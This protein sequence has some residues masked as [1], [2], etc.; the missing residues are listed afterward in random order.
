[1][2]E[3][4]RRIRQ[5]LE[6]MQP[7]AP[8]QAERWKRPIRQHDLAC[9][10]LADDASV[11]N[12]SKA[13]ARVL[14]HELID[15]FCM[16]IEVP[17]TLCDHPLRRLLLLAILAVKM[18]R[19][20]RFQ[21]SEALQLMSE[22]IEEKDSERQKLGVVQIF[23]HPENFNP[24]VDFYLKRTCWSGDSQSL[25]IRCVDESTAE[26]QTVKGDGT[27][28]PLREVTWDSIKED[29]YRAAVELLQAFER[30]EP[31]KS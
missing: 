30:E 26:P 10:Q 31:D 3:F 15:R 8:G 13:A 5:L 7:L 21:F 18:P 28:I 23:I 27:E 24:P 29:P 12:G 4:D 2:S 19:G 25:C 20:W 16:Q 1:M 9:W 6:T 22:V 14:I 17:L 11:E